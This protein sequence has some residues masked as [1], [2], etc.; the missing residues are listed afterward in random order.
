MKTQTLLSFLL[1][2]LVFVSCKEK[3]DEPDIQ[4]INALYFELKQGGD[5]GF[6][7][8]EL[9]SIFFVRFVP[10]SDPLIAD[11]LFP[12][13]NYPMGAGKFY[14]ND[15]YPFR[16]D[17]SPYFPVYGYMIV[18]PGTNYRDTISNIK[19]GGQYDGECGYDNTLK[20]YTVNG[21]TVDMSGSQD[22]HLLTRW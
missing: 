9:N 1:L 17:Q 11:T 4:A 8:E 20:K 6:T 21:D 12:Q 5:G 10:M 15:N 16:N 22:F 2:A 19:L 14:I 13:G 7:E 3:C 18:D